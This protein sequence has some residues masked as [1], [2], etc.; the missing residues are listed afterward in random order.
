MVAFIQDSNCKSHDVFI[1]S[2]VLFQRPGWVLV[3][4]WYM[5]IVSPWGGGGVIGLGPILSHGS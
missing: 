2:H 1:K 4:S 3:Y 5:S